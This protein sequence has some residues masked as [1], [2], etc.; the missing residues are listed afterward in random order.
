[1][2]PHLQVRWLILGISLHDSENLGRL[3]QGLGVEDEMLGPNISRIFEVCNS[4]PIFLKD[5]THVG[6]I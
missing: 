1:M 4:V 3:A 5:F 6:M 2:S